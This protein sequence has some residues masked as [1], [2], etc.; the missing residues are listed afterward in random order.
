MFAEPFMRSLSLAVVLL[1]LPA[2]ASA[3]AL[4]GTW[5]RSNGHSR[6]RFD[7][8]GKTTCGAIAWIKP[9]V[10]TSAHIGQQVFFDL[11]K[12][13]DAQWQGKAFNPEDGR[14]YTGNVSVLGATLVTKGC[15]LG[16][17][18]CKSETWKKVD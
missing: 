15:V 9:G 16:G 4:S 7:M 11:S 12:A 17:L 5:E 2:M 14:T 18:I 3:A 6:L 10:K 8:C 13:G 1:C